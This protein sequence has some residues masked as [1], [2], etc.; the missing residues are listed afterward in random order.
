VS[1]DGKEELSMK[2]SRRDK[3]AT[4]LKTLPE[5]E[6]SSFLAAIR[7]SPEDDSVRLV[8]ADWLEERGDSRGSM[9]RA[10]L[11]IER[12]PPDTPRWKELGRQLSP[13]YPGGPAYEEWLGEPEEGGAWVDYFHRGLLFAHV[14]EDAD[15]DEQEPAQ[16][17]SA[18]R[19]GWVGKVDFVGGYGE[20]FSTLAKGGWPSLRP[21]PY[22]T[23]L[24]SRATMDDQLRGPAKLVNL[25][26]FS[27][28]DYRWGERPMLT[29]GGLAHFRKHPNL[30]HL[31]AYGRFTRKGVARLASIP[32]LRHLRLDGVQGDLDALTAEL[33]DKLPGCRITLRGP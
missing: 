14:M 1:F 26:E 16:F 28:E 2:R 29:D 20:V 3:P 12:T 18:V 22:I 30:E 33:L 27:M 21:T 17:W 8:F 32:R 25:H 10:A 7:A 15:P 4:G 6:L 31:E 24:G 9:I 23:A 13:W 5:R 19:Q 11:E